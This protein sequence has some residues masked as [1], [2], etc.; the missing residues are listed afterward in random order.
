MSMKLGEDDRTGSHTAQKKTPGGKVAASPGGNGSKHQYMSSSP[1]NT[2]AGPKRK[3]ESRT[4]HKHQRT[5][6]WLP[7]GQKEHYYSEFALLRHA[8]AHH[9]RRSCS[10]HQLRQS[11]RKRN[12]RK[13]N[14]RRQGSGGISKIRRREG[15]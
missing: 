9:V 15:G 1:A 11:T 4:I 8:V 5:T 10:H 13:R 7:S 3:R 6:A 14:A 2:E 12:Q